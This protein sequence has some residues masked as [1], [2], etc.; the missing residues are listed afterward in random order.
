M[1][2]ESPMSKVAANIALEGGYDPCD[3]FSGNESFWLKNLG[4]ESGFIPDAANEYCYKVLP[5]LE[6]LS[7]GKYKCEYENDAEMIGFLSN[8][9]VLSLIF[10]LK[11][12]KKY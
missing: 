2:S 7:V 3:K 5:T 1:S 11:M 10:L 8:H 12:G 9:E 6:T 4:C